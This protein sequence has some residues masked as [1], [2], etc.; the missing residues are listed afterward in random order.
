MNLQDRDRLD[1]LLQ[2]GFDIPLDLLE[3][4]VEAD[5]VAFLP[6]DNG[7]GR[8]SAIAFVLTHGCSP[9]NKKA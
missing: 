6:R 9:K 4:M 2:A 1:P 5:D 3:E 8:L 7:E